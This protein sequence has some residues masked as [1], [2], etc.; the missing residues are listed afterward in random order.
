MILF[1]EDD[2]VDN[3]K[4]LW[5]IV[6]YPSIL[7]TIN[8]IHFMVPFIINLISV[9][10][11]IIMSARQQSALKKKKKYQEILKEQ[12]HQHKN[13]LIGPCALAILAVPRLIISFASG[14]ME[15]TSDS[16]LFL[17][18]YFISLIPYLLTFIL[19]VVPSNTY[20][21]AS[22]TAINRYRHIINRNS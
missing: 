19:F 12:I 10:V 9:L 6:Q 2:N 18:G 11:I 20:K 8:I 1:I 13:L 22:Q 3:E 21:D 7:H 4:T 16:W 14:C 5:C 15:S 17:F